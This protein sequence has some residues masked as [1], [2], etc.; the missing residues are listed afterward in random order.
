MIGFMKEEG[1]ME[2]NT[3]KMA[4]IIYSVAQYDGYNTSVLQTQKNLNRDKAEW[5]F[6]SEKDRIIFEDLVR[7]I[8]FAG[9]QTKLTV[10]VFKGINAQMNSKIEGQ[11]E[12]PGKLRENVEIYVGDYIPPRTVT[13]AMVEREINAVTSR[14]VKGAWEL[15]ARL[16]KLQAFDNGNKRT[17]LISANLYLGA[18]TKETEEYLAIPTDFRRTQFDANLMYY[19][20]AD[21]WD[22]HMPDVEYSLRQFVSFAADYTKMSKPNKFEERIQKVN[23]KRNRLDIGNNPLENNKNKRK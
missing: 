17:A 7:A 18:L 12:E 19:Y 10:D 4:E 23:K 6:N 8:H 1:G 2:M 9:Q 5:E 21:D 11:P 16:A 13:P 3:K 15:Y 22:D 20:M 14:D